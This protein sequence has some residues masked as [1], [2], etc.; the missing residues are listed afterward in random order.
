MRSARDEPWHALYRR[1]EPQGHGWR[2]PTT[3]LSAEVVT[4]GKPNPDTVGPVSR[5]RSL[6]VLTLTIVAAAFATRAAFAAEPGSERQTLLTYA[7][8]GVLV[9][10]TFASGGRPPAHRRGR[11]PVAGPALTAFALFLLFVVAGWLVSWLG[12]VDRAVEAV[13]RHGRA[14]PAWEVALGATVAGAAEEAFYRGA[15]WE[16]VRLPLVT[17]ALAHMATTLP[18]GNVALTLAAGVLGIVVGFSRRASGGW[19]APAVTHVVWMLLVLAWL[20]V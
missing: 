16:R 2:A 10:G 4:G 18:A 19:W 5:R 14:G 11:R 6:L 7:L 12:P 20:P 1:P 3:G 17:T 8:A 13:V 15:L 9:L